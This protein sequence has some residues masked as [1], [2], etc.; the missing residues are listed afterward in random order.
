MKLKKVLLIILL[1]IV[2]IMPTFNVVYADSLSVNARVSTT[3]YKKGDTVI[4]TVSLSN[5]NSTAGIYGLSGKLVYDKEVFEA[6]T[7]DSTG[8]TDSITKQGEW[9]NAT[10]NPTTNEFTILTATPAKTSQNIMQISLKV[11]DNAKL[12]ETIIMLN[13]LEASNSEEDISTSPASISVKIIEEVLPVIQPS[14]SPIVTPSQTTTTGKLPQTGT[15][16]YII[17]VIVGAVFISVGTFMIYIRYK[18]VR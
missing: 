13:D 1:T 18:D 4:V 10:Y 5:I 6:I 8:N 11:K 12:G 17:P 7:A 14:P 16:S 2:L 15:D 3:E 9:S